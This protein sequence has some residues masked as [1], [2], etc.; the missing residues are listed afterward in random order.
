MGEAYTEHEGDDVLEKTVDWR[1]E[2]AVSDVK[3]Q[4]T[5]LTLGQFLE[6]IICVML[7]YQPSF[8][9]DL[10]KSIIWDPP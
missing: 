10:S 8:T 1:T 5:W 6:P 7:V 9:K 4:G 3:D 2:G